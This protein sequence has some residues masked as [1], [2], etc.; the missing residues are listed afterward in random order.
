MTLRD[1]N[2]GEMIGVVANLSPGGLLLH[3]KASFAVN[4][5]HQVQ[6]NW[7]LPDTPDTHGMRI[8]ITAMWSAP[9]DNGEASWTGFQIID[10]SDEDQWR[11][12]GL[13]SEQ[14]R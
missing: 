13:I 7:R 9:A 5:T 12:Q 8:G 14:E 1:E 10:I 4:A 3:S 2:G 6:L 11:L